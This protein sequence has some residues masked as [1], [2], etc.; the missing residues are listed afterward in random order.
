MITAGEL[1][2]RAVPRLRFPFVA[3]LHRR[4]HQVV[5]ALKM[6]VE[7]RLGHARRGDDVIDADGAKL[8]PTKKLNR[9]RDQSFA[10]GL[11][12]FWKAKK[13]RSRFHANVAH[14]GSPARRGVPI[15]HP[16]CTSSALFLR[17]APNRVPRPVRISRAGHMARRGPATRVCRGSQAKDAAA[18]TAAARNLNPLRRKESDIC[19]PQIASR[20]RRPGAPPRSPRSTAPSKTPSSRSNRG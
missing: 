11:G 3:L 2:H 10:A 7:G 14:V 19:N 16:G 20:L 6:L 17:T 12:L 5:L 1:A 8:A 18:Q 13:L 4:D 9:C 15:V